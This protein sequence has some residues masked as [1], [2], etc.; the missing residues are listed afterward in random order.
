MRVVLDSNIL[1]RA[2]PGKTSAA[3]EVLLLLNQA[4]HTLITAGPLLVEL[5]RILPYP[6]VRAVHGLDNAGIQAYLQVVQ[7]GSAIVIPVSPPPVQTSDPD[8]DLVIAAA[9][10]GHAEV[11]CTLDR[12]F[13]EASVQA[14]CATHGI[15]VLRD[16]D[17]LH[18]LRSQTSPPPGTP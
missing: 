12:H 15:R 18:E 4:P 10:A 1:A 7:L 6:R 17:L 2:T 14:A 16:I 13:F 3:R 8:D 9:V 5:A 11:I